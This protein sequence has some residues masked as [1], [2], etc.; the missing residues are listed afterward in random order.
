MWTW[1]V[2]KDSLLK[3]AALLF[4]DGD[5]VSDVAEE[6]DVSRSAAGRLRKRAVAEG[7]LTS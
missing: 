7:L 3:R 5:S 2:L 4:T 6:L 1:E